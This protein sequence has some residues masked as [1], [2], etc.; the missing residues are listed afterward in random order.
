MAPNESERRQPI[1][2]YVFQNK[3]D[4]VNHLLAKLEK[5]SP[6]KIQKTLYLLFAFYGATYGQLKANS[7]ELNV[8]NYPAYLFE[9]NFEA[10]YYGPVD[11][12]V[13]ENLH[14]QTYEAIEL[15][16]KAFAET[17]EPSEIRNV[18]LFIGNIIEQTNDTDDFTLIGRVCEDNAWTSAINSDN[19]IINPQAIIDEYVAKYI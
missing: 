10:W 3:T 17:L 5:P 2:S 9:P 16:D 1:T 15:K 19:K 6:I 18:R 8:I 13:H 11:I 4:L 7:S 14:K 12:D